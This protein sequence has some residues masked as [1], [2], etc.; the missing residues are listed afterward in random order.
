MHFLDRGVQPTAYTPS[1]ALPAVTK[2]VTAGNGGAASKSRKPTQTSSRDRAEQSLLGRRQPTARPHSS[3]SQPR[4]PH[5]RY[6]RMTKRTALGES[7]IPA[8]L[9]VDETDIPWRMGAAGFVV[10][11]HLVQASIFLYLAYIDFRGYK[12]QPTIFGKW[13]K[14]FVITVQ[15]LL[16]FDLLGRR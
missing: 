8:P 7:G 16:V 1:P 5:P 11:S 4:H 13:D 9:Y 2:T 14:F 3:L 15:L 6:V 12:T 10:F